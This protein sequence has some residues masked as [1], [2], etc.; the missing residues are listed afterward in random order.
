VVEI[1]PKEG[2]IAVVMDGED[3][4][5]LLRIDLVTGDYKISLKQTLY[6]N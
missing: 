4:I 5:V 6:K 1:D 3:G 2:L